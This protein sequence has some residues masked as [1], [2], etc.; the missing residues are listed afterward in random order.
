MKNSLILLGFE[1]NGMEVKPYVVISLTRSLVLIL[2][3]RHVS[4][5]LEI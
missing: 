4:G 5:Y 3:F 2:V 1:L